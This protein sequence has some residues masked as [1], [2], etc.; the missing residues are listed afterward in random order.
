MDKLTKEH[1]INVKA[2]EE[3]KKPLTK[4]EQEQKWKEETFINNTTLP[5]TLT[6]LSAKQ[7]TR[8]LMR[9]LTPVPN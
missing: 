9:F 7:V 6:I 5:P 8:S 1:E 4:E 3:D 2:K